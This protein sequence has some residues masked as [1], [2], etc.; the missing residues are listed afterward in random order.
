[1]VNPSKDIN[2]VFYQQLQEVLWHWRYSIQLLLFIF[3]LMLS[4]IRVTYV[5]HY[6]P[7]KLN[8]LQLFDLLICQMSSLFEVLGICYPASILLP[9][10]FSLITLET[11]SLH[12][13]LKFGY[14]IPAKNDTSFFI[15]HS[16]YS[17]PAP[18]VLLR[19]SI[20]LCK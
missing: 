15:I 17:P 14:C 3:K 20:K 4:K 2:L 5:A 7:L 6:L 19:D 1:M 18:S 16:T 8:D 11:A 9:L 13:H 12:I 10:Y